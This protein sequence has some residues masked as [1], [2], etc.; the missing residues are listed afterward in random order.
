MKASEGERKLH[1]EGLG[2][3]GPTSFIQQLFPEGPYTD[4][5]VATVSKATKLEED[6][7]KRSPK[8]CFRKADHF[9]D[10]QS[11]EEDQLDDAHNDPGHQEGGT[12]LPNAVDEEW[13]DNDREDAEGKADG[14]DHIESITEPFKPLKVNAVSPII[15]VDNCPLQLTQQSKGQSISQADEERSYQAF[16]PYEKDSRL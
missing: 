7:N 2:C 9:G 1:I 5:D 10:N 8:V 14:K 11:H 4:E 16:D 13:V 6:P 3:E 15:S 12:V